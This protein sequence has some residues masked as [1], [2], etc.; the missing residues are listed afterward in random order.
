M[1]R[2]F[3]LVITFLAV[4]S[5][6]FSTCNNSFAAKKSKPTFQTLKVISNEGEA[7]LYGSILSPKEDE[8][9]ILLSKTLLSKIRKI[10][11]ANLSVNLTSSLD[12]T[13]TYTVPGDA[14]SIQRKVIN[15][16]PGKYLVISLFNLSTPSGITISP[17]SLPTDDYRLKLTGKELDATTEEFN[18]QTPAL[19]VGTVDSETTGLVSIKDLF[20][21]NISEK[22]VVTNPNGTFFTEVRA[23]KITPQTVARKVR[24]VLKAQVD[25]SVTNDNEEAFE[26][27][28]VEEINTCVI[29]VEAEKHYLA[30]A[31]L[32]NDPEHNA[33]ITNKNLE[34]NDATT[35]TANL[36]VESAKDGD[37]ELALE[38]A[39][40]IVN[41][42]KEEDEEDFEDGEDFTCDIGDIEQFADRCSDD[43]QTLSSI[44]KDF[45][46]FVLKANCNFP[47]FKLIKAILPKLPED[48]NEFVGRGYCEISQERDDDRPCDIYRDHILPDFKKGLISQLPCPP[49]FC[50]EFRNIRPPKC[51]QPHRICEE[52]FNRPPHPEPPFEGLTQVC[53]GPR[54]PG[55]PI[56]DS[57]IHR[58]MKDL[59]CSRI[60]IDIKKEEC[61]SQGFSGPYSP[62]WVAESDDEGNLYCVP[63]NISQPQFPTGYQ[64]PRP[65]STPKEIANECKVNSCHKTCSEQY[66][67]RGPVVGPPPT[68][69]PH[70]NF[71]P[72]QPPKC[73]ECDCHRGCDAEAGRLIE[74]N[75][76]DKY[77]SRE[78]CEH[79]PGPIIFSQ[80]LQAQSFPQGS[81]GPGRGPVGVNVYDCLC[82]DTVNN[83]NEKGYVKPEVQKIC[84]ED[85]PPGY[86][87]DLNS[88][89]CLPIC[90][91]EKGFVRD[92]GGICRK[93]C[94]EGSFDDG[95]GYCRCPEGQSI[96][97]SGKCE[98]YPTCPQY[99]YN[100]RVF[101]ELLEHHDS[102]NFG[103]TGYVSPSTGP[104]YIPPGSTGSTN[105]LPPECQKC[106]GGQVTCP[107]G[108]I[109]IEENVVCV[110]AP[111]PPIKRCACP[112]RS[113]PGPNGQCGPTNT[114]CSGN[115]Y[116][117][118][119]PGPNKATCVCPS[120][121]PY[122]DNF[123]QQCVA[124]CS[125]GQTPSS[126][127]GYP[128]NSP[129]PCSGGN[130]YNYCS[131]GITVGTNS[132][133]CN[134]ADGAYNLNG[135]C[136]CPTGSNSPYSKEYGCSSSTCPP[137]TPVKCPDGSC[138]I[139]QAN[140]GITSCPAPYVKNPSGQPP[141]KCPD[142]TPIN[143]NS[144]NGSTCVA[145]CPS[146]LIADYSS[147]GSS[148]TSTM[149][150][151]LCPDKTYPT[152][153]VCGT[154]T[155][156]HI[157]AAGEA[158]T[159]ANP[160][161]CAGGG[162]FSS[163]NSTGIC[164]CTN[165]QTYTAATGCGTT[166][167]NYCP[168]AIVPTATNP[169]TCNPAGG[170]YFNSNGYCTCP[171]GS[172]SPYTKETGCGSTSRPCTTGEGP[173]NNC[174]CFGSA[175]VVDGT[176]QCPNN[177]NPAYTGGGC[178][179]ST[180]NFCAI[181][182]S[183]TTGCTCA[184]GATPSGTNNTCQCTNGQVYASGGCPGSTTTT[185]P[186]PYITNPSGTPPCKCP[187]STPIING[188]TCVAACPLP[189]TSQ[190][191]P[192]GQQT[193]LC[194]AGFEADP[195]NVNNCRTV[196]NSPKSRDS[197]G[198]CSC[199]TGQT[200]DANGQCVTP[201]TVTLSSAQIS[202]SDLTITYSKSGFSECVLLI[203]ADDPT[204]I[205]HNGVNAYGNYCNSD[206]GTFT[207]PL[208]NYNNIT[209]G[210]QVKLCKG[211]GATGATN[212]NL[213]SPN[214]CSNLV[215]VP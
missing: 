85:C 206:G 83:F 19:F 208:N 151:C 111:C 64:G 140:C 192:S 56:D 142:A 181:G 189:L 42:L 178:T 37:E 66:G 58:P 67:F 202:G 120:G 191:G 50:D 38:A 106:G 62:S 78:C 9:N 170:S 10:G 155:T 128:D 105:S 48:A 126:T 135:Y 149:K 72:S 117:N 167:S 16:K 209:N 172:S 193:C 93:K 198:V 24:K 70:D 61:S 71:S 129:I 95:T 89:Q 26:E 4:V 171:S 214:N 116:P 134:P 195:A 168:P 73:E 5:L 139:S 84:L 157:C 152:N 200:E 74:C 141:C 88:D 31:P 80:T 59:Y 49:D 99:C 210:Y 133:T 182:I 144:G 177:N 32:D 47:E 45:R 215:T 122:W 146:G 7:I 136:T 33:A 148:T 112:D 137:A 25:G 76:R 86:E 15:K 79:G 185:C 213:F 207:Y 11:I 159:I 82:K 22:I 6:F 91:K 147:S 162:T 127:V 14:L 132:C 186:A 121:L 204:I 104:G 107:S 87:K 18:Y 8:A 161:Y 60:G 3:F 130:Q 154:S 153:G 190:V 28:V 53:R 44:G 197:A 65:P 164:S 187:D 2:G 94:P 102:G 169:C 23:S 81:F 29:D 109:L 205:L 118:P 119:N 20:G 52:E 96:G 43:P 46:E 51:F 124:V 166:S 68:F 194:P 163:A 113:N 174:Y 90:D 103:G 156:S 100:Y 55:P 1:K 21:K 212:T 92:P 158:A 97:R 63:S 179:G 77:F 57:C 41:D 108:Q 183:T 125:Q 145:S 40:D 12:S 184:S 160:C 196:C 138:A 131:P 143:Y 201:Q 17:S 180:N 35:L 150:D 211:N 75:D 188:S 30:I 69:S 123:T 39:K 203:K 98:S 27:E 199:P 114:T 175:T 115:M 54:C 176:C 34:V 36:A 101:R 110:T 165:G 173:S 13:K